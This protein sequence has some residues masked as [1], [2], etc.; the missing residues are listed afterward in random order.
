MNKQTLMNQ[1]K[2]SPD[3]MET[4]L[5]LG[6]RFILHE[7]AWESIPRI[8]P[9]NENT[10]EE[11]EECLEDVWLAFVEFEGEEIELFVEEA[12]T[13]TYYCE[14]T[15]EDLKNEVLKNRAV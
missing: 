2:E 8:S 10:I 6:L 12:E 4:C 15:Y 1:I 13:F 11:E 7:P 5:N 3:I 9:R 14:P